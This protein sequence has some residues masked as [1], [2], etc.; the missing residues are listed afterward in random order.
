[1]YKDPLTNQPYANLEAFK[2]IRRQFACFNKANN[3]NKMQQ[4]MRK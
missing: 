1:M 4:Q 2:E 3:I